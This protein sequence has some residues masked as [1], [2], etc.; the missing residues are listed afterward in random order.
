VEAGLPT[1]K[2][3][4]QSR[5]D[6]IKVTDK[7]IFTPEGEIR[8]EF[9]D[10]IHPS[11]QQPEPPRAAA[12]P[13]PE[14]SPAEPTSPAE[15]PPAAPQ[16]TGSTGA[17][18]ATTD[19]QKTERRR[20][21]SAKG[22]NPNTPFTNFTQQLIMQGYIS[23]GLL[24]SPYAAETKIDVDAARDMIDILTL[25]QEKTAGNLTPEEEDFLAMHLGELKLAYVQRTKKI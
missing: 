3:D 15:M 7:R 1:D 25:L 20:T 4:K 11:E 21:M 10:E 8:E 9:R 6:Q 5:K 14:P 18:G 12:A 23:L 17:T 13:A 2:Q 22:E 24:R 16:A 19:A